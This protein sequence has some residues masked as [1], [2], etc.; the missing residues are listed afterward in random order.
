MVVQ[1]LPSAL[2]IPLM[3]SV[4]LCLQLGGVWLGR[5][6]EGQGSSFCQRA[7]SLLDSPCPLAAHHKFPIYLS[8]LKQTSE[9]RLSPTLPSPPA[10]GQQCPA[11]LCCWC[12]AESRCS[13]YALQVIS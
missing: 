13:P 11:H 12:W 9:S 1:G 8:Q 4:E 7:L 2:G 3:L 5:K 6:V 10:L